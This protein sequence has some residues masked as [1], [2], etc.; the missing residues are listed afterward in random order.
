MRKNS[1]KVTADDPPKY[2][3]SHFPS[4]KE[5]YIDIILDFII[6]VGNWKS[7]Q[8]IFVFFK[9]LTSPVETFM[10]PKMSFWGNSL[11]FNEDRIKIFLGHYIMN[12]G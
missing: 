12:S 10:G 11:Y 7:N 9:V 1:K 5:N 6:L 3:P 2:V 8:G 4:D